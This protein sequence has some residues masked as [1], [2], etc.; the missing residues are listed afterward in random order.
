MK[1]VMNLFILF[2]VT[3]SLAACEKTNNPAAPIVAD[4]SAS[5]HNGTFE[6]TYKDYKNA[7]RTVSLSGNISFNFNSDSTYTYD[8]V[9]VSSQDNQLATSLHDHGVYSIK[10]D[11]IEMFDDAAK[12][13]NPA[14]Q[15]SLYLSGIYSYI[16]SENQTIIE[17]SGD[18]GS[19]H[20][21]LNN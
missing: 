5:A 7:S 6:V 17:G 1:T 19:V 8:A 3:F 11:R 13:M 12:M 20:I 14:W 21:V 4:K 9:I 2:L 10:G 15:A 18:Y 16:Q